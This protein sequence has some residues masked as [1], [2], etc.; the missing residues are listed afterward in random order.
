MD[1]K[2]ESSVKSV[3]SADR[4]T[5]SNMRGDS[6]ETSKVYKLIC[7]FETNFMGVSVS[8]TSQS[9]STSKVDLKSMLS[10]TTFGETGMHSKF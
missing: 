4:V 6:K 5:L 3:K 9:D 7:A 1:F 10:K 8:N 2:R